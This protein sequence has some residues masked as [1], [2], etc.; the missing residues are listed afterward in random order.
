MSAEVEALMAQRDELLSMLS[1]IAERRLT[2]AVEGRWAE[3]S[4]LRQFAPGIE[5]YLPDAEY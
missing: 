4:D 2:G 1:A 5:K 3:G